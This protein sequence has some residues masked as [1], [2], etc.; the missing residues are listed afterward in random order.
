MN[1]RALT[2]LLAVVALGGGLAYFMT[3]GTPSA[4][5]GDGAL[6]STL[7]SRPRPAP[8]NEPRATPG[9]ERAQLAGLSGVWTILV[10]GQKGEPL[11]AARI[12]A[13]KGSASQA[14]ESIKGR[15]TFS[16]L[17]P[18]SW[19]LTVA[20]EG[21]PTWEDSVVVEGGGKETRTVVKLTNEIRVSG[22][23]LDE[24]GD[25]VGGIA[26][27]LLPEHGSHPTDAATAKGVTQF[28]STTDGRFQLTTDQPGRYRV[29]VGRA[30]QKPRFESDAFELAHGRERR[31]KVVVPARA[32]L[33][34]DIPLDDHKG[35]NVLAVLGQREGPPPPQVET[36]K[37]L[38]GDTTTTGE[39]RRL[40]SAAESDAIRRKREAV[41]EEGL[42]P[43]DDE[44]AK[45]KSLEQATG[46][47]RQRMLEAEQRMERER[48]RRS[49]LIEEGWANVRSARFDP[50]S[51]GQIP[52]LPEGRPLRFVLYRGIEGFQVTETLVAPP[53]AS[54]RLTLTPPAPFP[55]SVELPEFP[56]VTPSRMEVTPIGSEALPLGLTFLD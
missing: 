40:L 41:G 17:E 45:A 5:A 54:V 9:L 21:L 44:I 46:E 19:D 4:P 38:D 16:G 35:P 50:G 31:A 25:P 47:Q 33:V 49:R 29:T 11:S 1:A 15:A 20:A 10:V 18:G 32:R 23:V 28:T 2:F 42:E 43:S 55:P 7:D 12:T 13:R 37:D 34:V 22:T 36:T 48:L 8:V 56:R 24:R 3:R 6:V 39:G 26:L 53:G 30:G 52:D 27:W 51:L 14:A